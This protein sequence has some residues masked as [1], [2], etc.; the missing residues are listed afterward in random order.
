MKIDV[1]NHAIPEQVLD[2]LRRE[3]AYGTR[4]ENG[5]FLRGAASF[6]IAAS[7]RDPEAKLAGL[8]A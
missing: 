3:P 4:I 2:L 8:E 5:R 7:F 1:H 6:P